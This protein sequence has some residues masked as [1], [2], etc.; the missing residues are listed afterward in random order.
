MFFKRSQKSDTQIEKNNKI[1]S[2]DIL[3]V[4]NLRKRTGRS[5]ILLLSKQ[6]IMRKQVS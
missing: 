2:I 4:L 1:Q 6:T 5:D 3:K